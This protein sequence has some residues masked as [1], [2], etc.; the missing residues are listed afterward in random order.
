M[1]TIG[2]MLS[3]SEPT[4]QAIWHKIH[5]GLI[6]FNNYS[7]FYAENQYTSKQIPAVLGVPPLQWMLYAPPK[8]KGHAKTGICSLSAALP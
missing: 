7:D 8:E 6:L 5:L 2:I 4:V 1:G 3:H